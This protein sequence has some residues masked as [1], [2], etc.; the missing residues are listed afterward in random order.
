MNIPP[1]ES[2]VQKQGK[3][4]VYDY[5]MSLVPFEPSQLTKCSMAHK[6]C[7]VNYSY[8]P[9][10]K[11]AHIMQDRRVDLSFPDQR[12]KLD[13]FDPFSDNGYKN[14][15]VYEGE[16]TEYEKHGQ[17]E[18]ETDEDDSDYTVDL[19]TLVDD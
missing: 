16:A 5:S 3:N 13:D 4:E 12:E 10:S 2:Y 6:E 19:K 7:V 11:E 17:Q 8:V 14:M 9:I 15:G 18:E 1:K